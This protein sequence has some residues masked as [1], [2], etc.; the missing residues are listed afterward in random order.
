MHALR[1]QVSTMTMIL[2]AR[3][4][5]LRLD[6]RVM[7]AFSVSSI[8][9]VNDTVYEGDDQWFSVVGVM[10]PGLCLLSGRYRYRLHYGES[11]RWY[12]V[13][14]YYQAR[15]VYSYR[16]ARNDLAR[17]YCPSS[18]YTI[19]DTRCYIT[20]SRLRL[21]TCQRYYVYMHA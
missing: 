3:L 11:G 21:Y 9:I 16:Y 4:W 15:H 18:M 5:C 6:S 1:F 14:L 20:I 7:A 2:W 10:W 17:G 12:V 13:L 19:C 8:A